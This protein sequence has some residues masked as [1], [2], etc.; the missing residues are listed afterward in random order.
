M[1]NYNYN[2]TVK[3]IAKILNLS[4]STIRMKIK[5]ER[6]KG[7]R[8]KNYKKLGNINLFDISYVEDLKKAQ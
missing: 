4:E 1:K 6:D 3:D 7:I 8:N 2:L 5:K